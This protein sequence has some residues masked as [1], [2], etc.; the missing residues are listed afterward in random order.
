M[1]PIRKLCPA[2]ITLRLIDHRWKLAIIHELVRGK[3]RF[4]RL[5]KTI[6]GI[7]HRV[8]STHLREMERDGLVQR[9]VF[10]QIPP[11]VEYSL[12]KLGQSL[13]PVLFAMHKWGA[14]Y[15]KT[16]SLR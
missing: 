16:L 2:E 3:R 13:K 4:S 5:E 1:S 12:T 9:E 8:L 10:P 14:R 11:R 6:P 7:S 15:A